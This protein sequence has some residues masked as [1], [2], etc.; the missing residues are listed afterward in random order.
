[1]IIGS[2]T[3]IGKRV[4]AHD[5]WS[6]TDP[7]SGPKQTT[8]GKPSR[9]PIFRLDVGFKIALAAILKCLSRIGARLLKN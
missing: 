1:M 5:L 9:E 6:L 4:N 2:E 7:E 8:N 3:R